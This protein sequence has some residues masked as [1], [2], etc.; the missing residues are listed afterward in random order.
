MK[1]SWKRL[2][3]ILHI[4]EAEL[5]W[6]WDKYGASQGPDYAKTSATDRT[7]AKSR[8]ADTKFST[9]ADF[10]PKDDA[11][12]NT[13]AGSAKGTFKLLAPVLMASAD[14]AF[15]KSHGF[16]RFNG[17]W[18]VNPKHWEKGDEGGPDSLQW[19]DGWLKAKTPEAKEFMR[20]VKLDKLKPDDIAKP[21]IWKKHF[22]HKFGKHNESI[23]NVFRVGK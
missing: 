7:S 19:N 1:T 23:K 15:A 16:K 14:K 5:N 12:V 4:D 17:D 22:E 21:D 18:L 9:A 20:I 10:E 3:E 11:P 2:L 13:D 6:K 8:P